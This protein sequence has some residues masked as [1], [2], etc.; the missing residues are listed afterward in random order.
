M[1]QNG[2]TD[3]S[4]A[5]E[6]FRR[7][8]FRA[9]LEQ[10]LAR[11]SGQSTHLL[12]YD[13]V[14]KKLRAT[15]QLSRGLQDIPLDAIIGSVG[16][17]T[18]FTRSFLPRQDSDEQRWAGVKLA[19]NDLSG[20]PPIEVYQIDQAYFVLDGNHRVS[21]ARQLGATHI[22]AYV[23]EVQT[24][25]P[26]SP[27]VQPD[28][29]ILKAE[30]AAFLG[31]TGLDHLRPDADLSVSVPGQ[32]EK[33]E[34]HISVHRYFMGIDQNKEIPYEEAVA[35]WYDTLYLPTAGVIRQRGM[36]RDFPDRTEADLYLWILEHRAALAKEGGWEA[37]P[38]SAATDLVARYSRTP[39]RVAGRI[40]E[41]IL[42]TVA[43]DGL[44]DGAPTGEWRQER[45]ADHP[46]DRLF[47]DILIAIDGQE[48][49][50]R[51]LDW[52]LDI[53]RREGAR[54]CGLHAVPS[55]A[56]REG[57]AVRAV[58]AEFE[59]RCSAA[60]VQGTLISRAGQVPRLVCEWARLMDLIVLS[61]SH[62]YAPQ[63][64]ARLGSGLHT[65]IRRCPTP[66]V[67]VP[68]ITP[69]LERVLL[70]Y[71][72]SPKAQE[73]L[74]VAAYLACCWDV[75]L[76]VLTIR[77]SEHVSDD[78]LARARAYLADRGVQ[79]SFVQQRGPVAQEILLTAEQQGIG[80]IV[81]G[82]YGFSPL[83]ESA[84]GSTV[85]DV[86]RSSPCPVLICQ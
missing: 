53:A 57:E 50:W 19:M 77:E 58:R 3:L 9:K 22:H 33:L 68:Q 67:A 61:L 47:A 23:T 35:H 56:Q 74:F 37:S 13:E 52:T 11:L 34:E 12:E 41:R 46:Q 15:T 79:A 38:E 65:I 51:A 71:D 16:R 20:L 29:L 69:R 39:Q 17:T 86:L 80:L 64:F 49:G 73:A 6:D 21:V 63:P 24:T 28:D 81:V 5:R 18:D 55:K 83:V 76:V 44:T 36:L 14:R 72:G 66:V 43:P 10:V 2:F 54:L 26:L 84:F 59:Q 31:R 8:R 62:P 27:D 1:I 78:A 30:Y 40:R 82:G 85:G 48:S 7:A 32:Y 4:Q 45:F 70:A 25:V 60:G 42:D 75:S